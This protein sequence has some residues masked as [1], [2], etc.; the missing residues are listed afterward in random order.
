MYKT[1]NQYIDFFSAT[2]REQEFSITI[3]AEIFLALLFAA[4]WIIRLQL[5][6]YIFSNVG[7]GESFRRNL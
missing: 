1:M 3:R 4:A 5:Q 6:P 7:A 2:R